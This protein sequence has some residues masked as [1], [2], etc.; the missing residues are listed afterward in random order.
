[1]PNY[2]N[3][4]N[5]IYPASYA[6]PYGANW[7]PQ[8]MATPVLPQPVQNQ[9]QCAMGY[10]SDGEIEAR[11]RQMP[12]GVTQYYMFDTNQP[13]IYLKSIN[14]MGMPNPMQIL[15]YTVR[16]QTS[17]LPQETSGTAEPAKPDMSQYVTRQDFDGLREEIRNM[18]TKMAQENNQ[19]GRHNQNQNRGGNP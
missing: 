12:A 8:P 16:G 15:D 19:N 3:P 11:G 5:N 6:G 4:Y 2:Y 18:I 13:V 10:V 1:M 7:S 17:A 9:P 14:Q